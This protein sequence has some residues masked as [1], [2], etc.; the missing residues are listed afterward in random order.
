MAN[1]KAGASN[2]FDYAGAAPLPAC[3]LCQSMAVGDFH[4]EPQRDYLRCTVCKIVFVHPAHLPSRSVERRIYDLHQNDPHDPAYRKFLSRL[5]QPLSK[6]LRVGAVGLD[7]GS[8]PGPTLHL[9]FEE[10]GFQTDFYDPN[11]ARDA[12]VFQKT[13]D[14]ITISEAVEHFHQPGRQL[15]QL[16]PL[17][18]PDGWLGIMTQRWDANTGF[19][20]W[21]YKR[22]PTH[23]SFFSISTFEWLARAWDATL[24]VVGADV[25]L[26]QKN[27]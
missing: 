9:M 13:Y 19:D 16:W 24:E 8:G 2:D 23:V 27:S 7:F 17:L 25:V 12:S 22:D 6:K 11:Y 3:P 15:S 21:Y 5:Y 14:F 18:T 20:D 10:A 26:F 1:A 4:R